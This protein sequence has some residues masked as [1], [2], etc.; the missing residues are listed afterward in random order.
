MLVSQPNTLME[1]DGPLGVPVRVD[2]A[3]KTAV[4]VAFGTLLFVGVMALVIVAA[5]GVEVFTPITTGVGVWIRGVGVGGKKGV[6]PDPGWK[7]QP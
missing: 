3:A 4:S 2:V 7:T 5:A 1:M 6:G